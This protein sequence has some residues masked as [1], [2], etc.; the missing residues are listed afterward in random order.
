MRTLYKCRV[1]MYLWIHKQIRFF[2]VDLHT[3]CM[4]YA[5]LCISTSNEYTFDYLSA[6]A[7]STINTCP[8]LCIIYHSILR[9]RVFF[10]RPHSLD[11][12]FLP[13]ASTAFRRILECALIGICLSVLT[14]T[15]WAHPRS[16]HHQY[17]PRTILTVFD[18]S[19][20][21]TVDPNGG[22]TYIYKHLMVFGLRGWVKRA[23]A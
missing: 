12:N 4:Y 3:V 15:I 6:H 13:F 23:V 8:E 7:H 5:A 18:P 10:Y 2:F 19:H 11:Y 20:T 14:N 1:C 17:P 22:N 16:Q 21:A 9:S